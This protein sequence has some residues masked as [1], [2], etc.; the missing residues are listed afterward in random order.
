MDSFNNLDSTASFL[1][2]S[3][4]DHFCKATIIINLDIVFF[5]FKFELQQ[6]Q[7]LQFVFDCSMAVIDITYS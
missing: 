1:W 6:E 4:E 3:Y 7:N 2:F 5:K